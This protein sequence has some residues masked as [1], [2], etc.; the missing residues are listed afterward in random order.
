[1]VVLHKRFLVV[2]RGCEKAIAR[3]DT[4]L[5]VP[6][7][8]GKNSNLRFTDQLLSFLKPKLKSSLNLNS[9]E[10]SYYHKFKP[11]LSIIMEDVFDL[12]GIE[13]SGFVAYLIV[14]ISGF[15]ACWTVNI[16]RFFANLEEYLLLPSCV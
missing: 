11:Y 10:V 9:G 12:K 2:L 16:S 6:I 4:F 15:V 13:I 7:V 5:L 8:P 1:M 3:H 14:D